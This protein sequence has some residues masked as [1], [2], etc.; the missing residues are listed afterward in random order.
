MKLVKTDDE[1]DAVPVAV[2]VTGLPVRPEELTVTVLVPAV[3]PRIRVADTW[4]L[5]ADTEL[6]LISEPPPPV[7]AQVTVVPGTSRELESVTT[8]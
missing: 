3:D 5:E 4:P 7:T 1:D 8:A 2:N 6:I